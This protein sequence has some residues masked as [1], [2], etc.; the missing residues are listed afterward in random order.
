[1]G[2]VEAMRK[3]DGKANES[4]TKGKKDVFHLDS[5]VYILLYCYER[6]IAVVVVCR[7]C[8]MQQQE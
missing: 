3:G 6:P 4:E 2:R 8:R 1:M 5:Y 7:R